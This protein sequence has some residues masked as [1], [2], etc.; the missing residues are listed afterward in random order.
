MR[1]PPGPAGNGDEQI[2]AQAAPSDTGENMGMPSPWGGKPQ[3]DGRWHRRQG[4]RLQIVEETRQRPGQAPRRPVSS[5]VPSA[6]YAR[7]AQITA[8]SGANA[9][10]IGAGLACTNLTQ[11][12]QLNPPSRARASLST[13]LVC[14]PKAH[15]RAI[16]NRATPLAIRRVSSRLGSSSA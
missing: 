15:C 11:R 2:P 10:Q 9:R 6:R 8:P 12:S 14:V 4:I 16:Q 5:G 13:I 3:A 1:A 7:L